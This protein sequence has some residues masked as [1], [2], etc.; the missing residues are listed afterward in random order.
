MRRLAQDTQLGRQ[1]L[2][3]R[4][5]KKPQTRLAHALRMLEVLSD[6]RRTLLVAADE[7]ELVQTVCRL[8]VDSGEYVE[9][10]FVF[11]TGGT[12]ALQSAAYA[13]GHYAYIRKPER[14]WQQTYHAVRLRS[15]TERPRAGIQPTAPGHLMLPVVMQS[16]VGGVLSLVAVDDR[17][18]DEHELRYLRSFAEDLAC[19]LVR[20]RED[21]KRQAAIE[22]LEARK[23]L[24]EKQLRERLDSA[25]ERYRAIIDAIPDYVYVK[26]TRGQI[27]L[28]NKAWLAARG[29]TLDGVLGKTVHD[30]YD[31]AVAQRMEERDRIVVG[32]G[33]PQV[34]YEERTLIR[35]AAAGA[36]RVRWSSTSKVPLKDANGRVIGLVGISRDI[37]ERREAKEA[38]QESE[39][40]LRAVFE[41]ADVGIAVSG[42]DL[43]YLRVNDE[44]CNIVGYDRAELLEMAIT[45]VN[46]E[47]NIEATL[48]RRSALLSRTAVSKVREKQLLRK[49][50]VLIWVA[51][52]TSLIRSSDGAP[53]YFMSI[54]QDISETK[55]AA[56]ALQESEEQFRQLSAHIPQVFWIAD[57]TFH[58][59]V[60]V[61]PACEQLLGLCNIDIMTNRRALVRSVHPDDRRR[62]YEHRRCAA[63]GTYDETYRIVRPD[64]SVRWLHDRGFPVWNAEGVIYRVAGIAEDV[65]DRKR[66]EERLVELAHYDSLT[67]LPN[68]TLLFDRLQQALA[69][70]KR[71]SWSMA[72]MFVDIDRFKYV[73]DSLGH[74][75][76]DQ[77]LQ[78]VAQRLAGCVRADDTVARLGGD[79]YA[80][81][82][83]WLAAAEDAATVARKIVDALKGAFQLE[84]T[85]LF[86]SASI[87]ITL[88]PDDGTDADA[89]LRHADIA[90]YRAKELGRNNFQ[91]YT[92]EMNAR[93]RELLGLERDLRHAIERD[94]FVVY[95]QP[96]VSLESGRITGV[97]ALLRWRHPQRGLV[98]P[99]EFIP[100]LEETGLIIE[101]GA[102]VLGAVCR[103]LVEWQRC[104]TPSVPVAVNLSARQFLSPDL[105]RNIKDVLHE[106]GLEPHLLEVEIT[107]SSAMANPADAVRTLEEL[108]SFGIAVAID[109]FGTGYSS[110]AYL[111]RFPLRALKIDRS[112]VR[113]ITTDPDDAAIT[114]AVISMAHSLA[115]RVVAEGVETREQL[116]FLKRC[117]CDEAQGYLYSKPLPGEECATFIRNR[118]MPEVTPGATARNLA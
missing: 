32:S 27:E 8:L 79:E 20:L 17:V 118:T 29:L 92:A 67:K 43:R 41:H 13:G 96:K 4:R 97:E 42:L 66:A 61:S 57:A 65:T 117:G 26:D 63:A 90:M 87:G 89:L 88:F 59:T 111:K 109:D 102:I 91:F 108:Q 69:Q 86:V 110:L 6:C 7:R 25:E 85:E 53:R 35:A 18:L 100:V 1:Q 19:A 93:T 23:R 62:V 77:L 3:K 84:R 107:E 116:E 37:T 94:E 49:D 80:I 114:Q 83:S 10:A 82:L 104:G 73:N 105:A 14:F 33:V 30:I 38:L 52:V 47:Q 45:D 60:Y 28:G 46:L 54:V 5:V 112:F 39:Q 64:G 55:R 31:P 78:L 101:A 75:A 113:D 99:V 50:G 72:V 106:H 44:F 2:A 74:M 15:I 76:G 58:R 22:S 95:Y 24:N 11:L 48:D 34:D 40:Q 71:N 56:A 36:E 12:G 68:R 98:A 9:A 51:V 115:L 16:E 21:R 81:V 70:A 103:Q